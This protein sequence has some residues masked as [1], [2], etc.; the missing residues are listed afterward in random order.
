MLTE[1][2][3]WLKIA[4]AFRSHDTDIARKGLCH[5]VCRL[6]QQGLIYHLFME[7]MRD[8]IKS[9]YHEPLEEFGSVEGGFWFPIWEKTGNWDYAE[10]RA[11]ICEIFA[12]EC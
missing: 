3:S 2:E 9:F 8:R 10:T 7:E 5:A 6:R 1:K 12:E 11:K 4:N